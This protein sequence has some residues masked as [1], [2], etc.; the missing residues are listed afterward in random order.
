MKRVEVNKS[1]FNRFSIKS[2][3]MTKVKDLVVDSGAFLRNSPLQDLG[4]NIY[5]CEEVLAEVKSKWAI[6]RLQ[7]LPY[8]IKL[9]E[10]DEEDLQFVIR[11]A[12]KTGDYFSLSK[13]DLKVMALAVC[14]ERQR[15]GNIDHLKTAPSSTQIVSNVPAKQP[16]SKKGDTYGFNFKNVSLGCSSCPF[17]SIFKSISFEF[18]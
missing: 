18:R 9:K 15:N 6:D 11:F 5:T 2:L 7:V 8:E 17:L 4:E 10:P 1:E 12:K 13:T 14:M 3:K 16:G